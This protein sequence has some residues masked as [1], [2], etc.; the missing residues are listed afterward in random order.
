MHVY[1]S[2]IHYLETV[3][4]KLEVQKMSESKKQWYIA[5]VSWDRLKDLQSQI[6]RP[7][8]KK[9]T[10]QELEKLFESGYEPRHSRKTK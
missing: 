9:G 10:V 5:S 6:D 3:F 4:Q 8:K 2:N 7:M 1:G